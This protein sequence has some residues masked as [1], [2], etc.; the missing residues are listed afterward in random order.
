MGQVQPYLVESGKRQR[1][2]RQ[3]LD[4]GIGFKAGMTIDLGADL[5]WL[6]GGMQ[7]GRA[8]MK[9]AA[10]IAQAGDGP[11]VE[12]VG[13]DP[14]DLGVSDAEAKFQPVMSGDFLLGRFKATRKLWG[15]EDKVVVSNDDKLIERP[16]E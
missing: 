8:R 13:V 5:Q 1:G 9:Y 4:L 6:A 15:A 7:P 14:R 3:F 16:V 12:Q 2:Q 11:A 10:G